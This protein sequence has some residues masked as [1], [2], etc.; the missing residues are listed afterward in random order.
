MMT[1][2]A[3][4]IVKTLLPISVVVTQAFFEYAGSQLVD[5]GRGRRSQFGEM[6]SQVQKAWV[7]LVP[8][9]ATDRPDLLGSQLSGWQRC[10]PDGGPTRSGYASE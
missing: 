3:A 2:M 10:L 1:I 9:G 6:L 7:T 8:S 4:N 5:G